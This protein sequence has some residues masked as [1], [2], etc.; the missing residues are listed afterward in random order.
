[1]SGMNDFMNDLQAEDI[2]VGKN[3]YARNGIHE[4]KIVYAKVRGT[5][6]KSAEDVAADKEDMKK[7][8]VAAIPHYSV[9]PTMQMMHVRGMNRTD[10]IVNLSLAIGD[11]GYVWGKALLSIVNPN[12]AEL[13]YELQPAKKDDDGNLIGKEGVKVFMIKGIEGRYFRAEVERNFTDGRFQG[14][15]NCTGIRQSNIN[16]S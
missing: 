9:P 12:K 7:K 10:Q 14:F 16:R 5:W 13:N 4:F 15:Y 8:V 2:Y 3:F 11:T 1:M 6:T